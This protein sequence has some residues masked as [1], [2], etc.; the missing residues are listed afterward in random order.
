MTEPLIVAI[1]EVSIN[2]THTELNIWSKPI[3]CSIEL[4]NAYPEI[5]N[6]IM[7]VI[8]FERE[9]YSLNV[10]SEDVRASSNNINTLEAMNN[11][12]LMMTRPNLTDD[13]LQCKMKL[14]VKNTDDKPRLVKF[15]EIV[16][17]SNY[18]LPT[19]P[20]HPASGIIYIN[21]G[22]VININNIHIIKGTGHTRY[23]TAVAGRIK[24][25]D[26]PVATNPSYAY[27]DMTA[28][29]KPTHHII[30]WDM[31]SNPIDYKINN[32]VTN[33][34]VIYACDNIIN[35]LELLA[36]NVQHKVMNVILTDELI[37]FD[38]NETNTIAKLLERCAIMWFPELTDMIS[39]IALPEH[40]YKFKMVIPDPEKHFIKLITNCKNIF[41][42]I[43][44]QIVI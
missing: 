19:F 24:P 21:P 41:V 38:T 36:S 18:K 39:I 13:D 22:D 9:G 17:T 37:A 32:S 1:K 6:A 31:P 30:M 12:N 43:K 35:R 40:T 42:K 44:K 8:T 7:R 11:I 25:L 26:R 15:S 34:L 4:K 33:R 2:I 23:I 14:S 28:V 10:S 20:V 29:S 5:C 16:Y 27:G 3:T